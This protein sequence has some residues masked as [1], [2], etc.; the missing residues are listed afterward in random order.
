M[1]PRRHVGFTLVELLAVVAL[2]AAVVGVGLACWRGGGDGAVRDTAVALLASR[3][4]ETRA[5][6]L[7]RGEP[8]RLMVHA[9]PAEPSRY[10]RYLVVAVPEDDGWRAADE[11]GVLPAG[12]VVLP[13]AALG[14]TGPGVVCRADDN[15]SRPS[16]GALRSTALRSYTDAGGTEE[17]LGTTN[18]LLVHFSAT[19]GVSA[20][21]IVVARASRQD[22]AVPVTMICVQPDA[23]AGLGLSS[24]GVAT[25][26]RNRAEF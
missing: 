10:L 25:V 5:L 7:D 21:D 20:G 14:T 18:W 3:L 16:G 23:V 22:E 24:N 9:D 19:G 12:V 11:G 13:A 1:R 15:W 26:L 2:M 17:F 6:A 8:A 4:A